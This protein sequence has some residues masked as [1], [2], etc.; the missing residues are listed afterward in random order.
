MMI[1]LI[2]PLSGGHHEVYLR[3]FAQAIIRAGHDVTVLSP[4]GPEIVE[5]LESER[6]IRSENWCPEFSKP[7]AQRHRGN[8][9]KE[10][11]EAIEKLGRSRGRMPEFAFL[12]SLDRYLGHGQSRYSVD[13]WFPLPFSGLFLQPW[14]F[15]MPMRYRWLRRFWLDPLEPLRAKKCSS[16][17]LLDP[18]VA[19]SVSRRLARPTVTFP[20]LA[21]KETPSSTS[22]LIT[23]LMKRANGRSIVILTGVIDGRK[24]I[25]RFLNLA[26][27]SDP[28]EWFAVVVGPIAWGALTSG[29][30]EKLKAWIN[31][32]VN[33]W[34]IDTSHL[35][36]D[37]INEFVACASAVWLGYDRFPFSSNLLSKAAAWKIP[38]LS[39]GEFLIGEQTR[40]FDLG[41][42]LEPE[43]DGEGFSKELRGEI[44]DLR[45]S[46]RFQEGCHRYDVIHSSTAMEDA[47]R[48]VL[49]YAKASL[50]SGVPSTMRR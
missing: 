35:R 41:L 32:R 47:F 20:D 28:D 50:Q 7:G 5:H 4:S 40:E 24:G 18:K 34:V 6:E 21:S 31:P 26:D 12:A 42:I 3:S 39:N 15:R 13:R 46:E 49:A 8:P 33:G 25:D 22:P 45:A 10:T 37:E 11:A 29:Q 48:E 36:D 43:S 23:E 2:D 9:W 1:A 38:V 17:C 14:M 30:S 19:P 27:H 16:V 44:L